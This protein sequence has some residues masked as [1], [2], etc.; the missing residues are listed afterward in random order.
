MSPFIILS[1]VFNVGKKIRDNSEGFFINKIYFSTIKWIQF[2][3]KV[4][5]QASRKKKIFLLKMAAKYL[6][7]KLTHH[8]KN[9]KP[10]CNTDI[11]Y[12]YRFSKCDLMKKEAIYK[13]VK[14]IENQLEKIKE[15]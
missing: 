4:N 10:C 11:L 13:G 7:F 3:R 8:K 1:K 14:F 9:A 12:I 6:R 15:V 5:S 2:E